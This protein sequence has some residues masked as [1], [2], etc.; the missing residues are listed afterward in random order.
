M[1]YGGALIWTGLARNLKQ[2]YPNKKVV[3]IYKKGLK[4]TLLG[5]PH[6]DHIIFKNNSDIEEVISKCKYF[7][8]KKRFNKKDW[9]VVDMDNPKLHYWERETKEKIFFKQGRHAI[10]IM[11]RYFRIKNCILRPV[12]NLTDEEQGRVDKLLKDYDLKRKG[13]VVIEPNIKE[14]SFGINREWFW[15]RWQQLA[16]LLRE[17]AGQV[18]V[19][20]GVEGS[21]VL[22]GVVNLVGRTSFRTATGLIGEARLFIGYEGGLGHASRAMDTKSVILV[23]GYEPLGLLSYPDNVNIYKKVGCAPCGL[24]IPCPYQRKCM[25]EISVDEVYKSALRLL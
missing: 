10:E 9:I 8:S 20:V 18:V 24:K 4:K 16:D 3:F 1:G 13:F 21:P 19:Q 22:S 2:I 14:S 17:E 5:K 6:P 12:L 15:E 11:C 25:K 7:F 23:S